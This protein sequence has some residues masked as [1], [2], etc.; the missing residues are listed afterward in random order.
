MYFTQQSLYILGKT[1]KE[2]IYK[3]NINHIIN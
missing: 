3:Y 2:I 1:T